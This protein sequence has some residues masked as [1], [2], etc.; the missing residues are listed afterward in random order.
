MY[1]D[2]RRADL[3]TSTIAMATPPPFGRYTQSDPIGLEGGINTYSYVAARPLQFSDPL[4]LWV[5]SMYN[6]VSREAATLAK[7]SKR[8]ASCELEAVGQVFPLQANCEAARCGHT[9]TTKLA[10]SVI[11]ERRSTVSKAIQRVH[12]L[13]TNRP[14]VTGATP[15][16]KIRARLVR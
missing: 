14:I 3:S 11:P 13:L 4:G 16:T 15:L 12:R 5:P 6:R 1:D 10:T 9:A 8:H 2:S 7:C